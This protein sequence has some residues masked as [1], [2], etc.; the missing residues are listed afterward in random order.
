[1]S[2]YIVEIL[3]SF[4]IELQLKDSEF[5]IKDKIIKSFSGLRGFKSVT[6]LVLEFKKGENDD[7]TK[8]TFLNS[9]SKTEVIIN[10]SDIDDILELYYVIIFQ[11]YC[12]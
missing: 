1:M 4:N 12:I 6:E 3:N 8:Y 9:N 5:V 2:T 10:K 11:I 7:E